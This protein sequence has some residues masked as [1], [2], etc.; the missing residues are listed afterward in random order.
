MLQSMELQRVGHDWVI[1]LNWSLPGGT[2][3]KIIIIITCLPMHM[4]ETEFRSSIRKIPWRR[5][6]QPTPI[7]LLGKFYGERTLAGCSPKGCK[8]SEHNWAC[9]QVNEH[10]HMHTNSKTDLKW[11][12]MYLITTSLWMDMVCMMLCLQLHSLKEVFSVDVVHTKTSQVNAKYIA[13]WSLF[14]LQDNP[15][16]HHW[17]S[18]TTTLMLTIPILGAL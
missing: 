14:P 1:E 6:R 15:S 3:G 12:E 17:E 11:D 18:N 4:Q 7:F 8:G 16:Q 5:K 9:M 2:S 13:S 10:A